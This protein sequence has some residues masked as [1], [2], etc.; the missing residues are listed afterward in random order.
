MSITIAGN[1][2]ARGNET[3]LF[4]RALKDKV[5]NMNH[6]I[7]QLQPQ[8]DASNLTSS[9]ATELSANSEQVLTIP[10][11]YQVEGGSSSRLITMS[12]KIRTVAFD[13]RIF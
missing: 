8:T 7:Q 4:A 13:L 2:E 5:E 11:Y 6:V 3:A 10:V 9:G 12:R 1:G